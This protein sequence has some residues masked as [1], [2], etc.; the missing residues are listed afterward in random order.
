M[1]K[2]WS[3]WCWNWSF[4][5]SAWRQIFNPLVSVFRWNDVKILGRYCFWLHFILFVILLPWFFYIL[6]GQPKISALC[7]VLRVN[8]CVW[9]V[10]QG[11]AQ[12]LFRYILTNSIPG[13]ITVHLHY[14]SRLHYEYTD[15]N[16]VRNISIS[17]LYWAFI[18]FFVSRTFCLLKLLLTTTDALTDHDDRVLSHL[19]E[20]L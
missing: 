6:P 1:G 4:S 5:W 14:A 15:I 7:E 2:C 13:T 16:P 18:I 9:E 20:T 8:C 19:N 17:T 3:L 10:R 11:H 12:V